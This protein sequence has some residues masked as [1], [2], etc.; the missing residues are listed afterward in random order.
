[1]TALKLPQVKLEMDLT[2]TGP[3]SAPTWTDYSAYLRVQDGVQ[4][5][6]GRQ[7]E[8]STV[9]A[10][11][12]G[13]TLNN[14]AGTF[15]GKA[16]RAPVRLSIRFDDSASYTVMWTG[17]VTGWQRGWTNGVRPVMQVRA[18]DA[19]MLL[20]KQTLPPAVRGEILADGPVAY[21]PLDE[22][23][24]ATA[25]TDRTGASGKPSLTVTQVGS[26]GT[27][28]FGA[29][30]VSDPDVS[31][32]VAFTPVDASN[33]KCLLSSRF[34]SL[35]PNTAEA[36]VRVIGIP[37]TTPRIVFDVTPVSGNNDS[38]TIQVNDT[39]GYA[40]AKFYFAAG[41][42]TY[43]ATS[44]VNV[45]DGN[46]HHLAAVIS[47]GSLYIYVD[48]VSTSTAAAGWTS[49][50]CLAR[51]GGGGT[52]MLS[53][54]LAHVAIHTSALS[55]TR[56]AAH[57]A[58][59]V[60]NSA[61]RSDQRYDRIGTYA[62]ITVSTPTNGAATMGAQPIAGKTVWGV[63]DEVAEAEQ[64]VNYISAA[65][66][67]TLA[68]RSTR[69]GATVAQT[70]LARDV[71]TATGFTLDDTYLLNDVTVT[72]PTGGPAARR[73]NTASQTAYGTRSDSLEVYYDTDAQVQY[74]AEWLA[75]S[76]G[77]PVERIGSLTIDA[78]AKAATVTNTT[79][80]ALDV[81]S[82]IRITISATNYDLVVEG[83]RDTV[84]I[85]GWKRTLNVSPNPLSSVWVLDD[86]TYSVL[87]TT[88]VLG[89]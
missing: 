73:R 14:D 58:A 4:W 69:Y 53:G 40:A 6:R 49:S 80:A 18:S 16:L 51:A 44:S 13:F 42:T 57:Y 20:E 60:G 35:T 52:Q 10:G 64:G 66:V 1:M 29:A 9:G 71:D 3:A 15:T 67:P 61:E 59:G 37:A 8:R 63:L 46:W 62:G 74:L 28:D 17:Y 65:G 70:F 87:D 36:W 34:E 30:G 19:V 81:S 47:G 89:F 45:C 25:A 5:D 77:T 50:P 86:S 43:T 2:G 76:R 27:V 55:S 39:T 7:D 75:N 56:I 85:G 11:T 32:A 88:T 84:D 12:A 79:L 41:L 38:L 48:G 83:L 54:A 24:G 68:V 82:L 22:A 26:G 78:T 31:S 33:G 23:A 21:W 72:R